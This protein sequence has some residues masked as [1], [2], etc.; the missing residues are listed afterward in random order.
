MLRNHQCPATTEVISLVVVTFFI[1]FQVNSDHCPNEVSLQAKLGKTYYARWVNSSITLICS[2]E[3]FTSIIWYSVMKVYKMAV[4]CL[5]NEHRQLHL[6]WFPNVPEI[7]ATYVSYQKKIRQVCLFSS[8]NGILTSS[9]SLEK[10]NAL[11]QSL[12]MALTAT[13][14]FLGNSIMTNVFFIC[15]QGEVRNGTCRSQ[16]GNGSY[17]NGEKT[18]YTNDE[19]YKITDEVV[20]THMGR[21]ECF[22]RI[23]GTYYVVSV[24]FSSLFSNMSNDTEDISN[25]VYPASKSYRFMSEQ[26]CGSDM[27]IQAANEGYM[28][29]D[30]GI[31]D[32]YV[33]DDTYRCENGVPLIDSCEYLANEFNWS[34][35]RLSRN[36]SEIADYGRNLLSISYN[37]KTLFRTNPDCIL[38]FTS[39]FT[40]VEIRQQ[41]AKS[42]VSERHSIASQLL[43]SMK[44][45]LDLTSTHTEN[46][47]NWSKDSET[48]STLTSKKLQTI[49]VFLHLFAEIARQTPSVI[50]LLKSS[51]KSE[52][53]LRF[54]HL[55]SGIRNI[56]MNSTQ[57]KVIEF[58]TKPNQ[59]EMHDTFVAVIPAANF[60]DVLTETDNIEIVGTRSLDSDVVLVD[61]NNG[62][63]FTLSVDLSQKSNVTVS[64]E[65]LKQ[66]PSELKELWS[67]GNCKTIVVG[68]NFECQCI[69]SQGGTFAIALIYWL[70]STRIPLIH[71][72]SISIVNYI[73]TFITIIALFLFLIFTRFIGV[74]RLDQFN[75]GFC[76]LISAVVSLAIPHTTDKQP[77]LCT[78]IAVAVCYF[79]LA[80]FSWKFIFGLNTLVLI[81]SPHS[82]YHDLVSK[83]RNCLPLVWIGY[84][85]PAIIIAL[86]FGYTGEVSN[87]SLCIGP[88]T[89][90]W[91]FIG[92]ITLVVTFNFIILSIVGCVLLKN[93]LLTRKSKLHKTTHF[94]VL[95]Q[96]MLTLG[97]P[98]IAI[99]I[100]LLD[101]FTMLIVVPVAMALT[102]VL[103]FLLVAVFDEENRFLL[104]SFI[105]THIV[106]PS[107]NSSWIAGLRSQCKCEVVSEIR[108]SPLHDFG[109]DYLSAND[110]SAQ[111]LRIPETRKSES[112]YESTRKN[113]THEHSLS[114]T[115]HETGNSVIHVNGKL[116]DDTSY[117]GEHLG[118]NL[119]NE[120][121]VNP[122]FSTSQTNVLPYF[123]SLVTRILLFV[124]YR[125]Y[126][127]NSNSLIDLIVIISFCFTN[128]LFLPV[129]SVFLC[130]PVKL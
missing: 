81:M 44:F 78:I 89:F 11:D 24:T 5:K 92:P 97:I 2:G 85:S 111:V 42:S 34:C 128:I 22:A 130:I 96:L 31:H 33:V 93:H 23:N 13:V 30:A 99:Y 105:F 55:S 58:S 102:A 46:G 83:P 67:D 118:D 6:D 50:D 56:T 77:V 91:S 82:R 116:Y 17:Y 94:L 69:P 12:S 112:V 47:Q 70:G 98:Y 9:V 37:A 72:H 26:M 45:A 109:R 95:T 65:Q 8:S 52:R 88:K 120:R 86:W 36:S 73:F 127:T 51:R 63:S 68:S 103:M 108:K 15:K 113:R 29:C 38:N 7:T 27:C 110:L 84:L 106:R 117:Y 43:D 41:L 39:R 115:S 18:I 20:P 57:G 66:N 75:I 16:L 125:E 53:S 21:H 80:A 79:P 122:C 54:W 90:R 126:L 19:F 121:D 74:F 101:A 61:T 32:C 10:L 119:K 60:P 100:Q 3:E 1:I 71:L 87:G 4:G 48:L 14:Y 104:R 25:W 107:E 76:L 49:S 59:S 64:C 114:I 28:L 124:Q 62:V 35:P 123:N 40:D 129:I